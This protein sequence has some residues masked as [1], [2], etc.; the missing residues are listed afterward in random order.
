MKKDKEAAKKEKD[1]ITMQFIL[2]IVDILFNK[3]SNAMHIV[4]PFK[5]G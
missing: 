3:C 4:P 2:I 5:S 1:G